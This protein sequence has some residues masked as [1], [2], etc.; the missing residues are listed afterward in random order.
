MP[1]MWSKS[2]T[3]TTGAAWSADL[4]YIV[5][6]DDSS[7]EADFAHSIFLIWDSGNWRP[8]DEVMPWICVDIGVAQ[9]HDRAFA[10]G[11]WGEVAVLERS[12]SHRMEAI[13]PNNGPRRRGPLRRL[14]I[15]QDIPL[16]CGTDR[17]V[18]RREAINDWRPIGP[19]LRTSSEEVSSFESID[20]F[21]PSNL[22]VVGTNGEI[23]QLIEDNWTQL[24]TPTNAIL[25]DVCC[26][27][28]GKAYA[29]GRGGTLI[30]GCDGSWSHVTH[31]FQDEDFWSIAWFQESIYLASLYGIY[32]LSGNHLEIVPIEKTEPVTC[33]RLSASGG[34]L[35]SI[36]PK[37]IM[38]LNRLVWTRVD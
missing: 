12:G 26:A 16:A 3:F 5:A 7:A 22:L 6:S 37:D 33:Y 15:I 14:R 21:S 29:C 38:M 19:E 30:V 8:L 24:D 1:Q 32:R 20:G 36:G 27:P 34:A 11:H 9:Q 13:M 25:N 28:D 18:Y 31:D 4:C 2:L 35:W 23:W 10:V 17:Q